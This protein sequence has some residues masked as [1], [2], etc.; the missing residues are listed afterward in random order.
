M[1]QLLSMFVLWPLMVNAIDGTLDT[2]FNSS[3][4]QPGVVTTTDEGLITG[5][6]LAIQ[7]DAKI[8]IAGTA[9]SGINTKFALARYTSSGT[10][11]TSFNSSGIQT[12]TINTSSNAYSCVIQP[13]GKIIIAG[14]SR[15]QT[16]SYH[17]TI[18]RYTSTGVL[19]TTF[20]GTGITTVPSDVLSSTMISSIALQQ[21]NKIVAAGSLGGHITV[22]RYLSNGSLDTTGFGG[23]Q[24]YV[25]TNLGADSTAQS[26]VLQSDGKIVVGG[27]VSTGF[28]SYDIVI[29]R[30]TNTGVL[31]TSFNGTGVTTTHISSANQVYGISMQEDG[32][33]VAV[34]KSNTSFCVLHY[35]TDGTLDTSFNGT[36]FTT[37][38]LNNAAIAYATTIQS[39]GKILVA[40]GSSTG[41]TNY[42]LIL[43]RYL[44]NGTLDPSFN[45]IGITTTHINAGS[46][47]ARSMALRSNGKIVVAGGTNMFMAAQYLTM[48]V[49]PLSVLSVQLLAKECSLQ[50]PYYS[51]LSATLIIKDCQTPS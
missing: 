39:N 32:K 29:A 44:D 43:A 11:D 12:T 48:P 3:S 37:E 10:L 2:S 27:Y 6:A 25:Q 7:D 22:A 14:R 50:I 41:V 26:I 5:S 45:N 15:I 28:L 42:Y 35:Q 51:Q 13:D 40:G 8:V 33:I 47:L 46:T 19:D 23:G 9:T 16:G 49:T 36:G 31:D 34:G 20:N 18:A 17:F 24:G 4:S 30:Y 38:L 1:K 21:D